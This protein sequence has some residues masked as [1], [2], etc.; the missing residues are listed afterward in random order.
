[1]E[2]KLLGRMGF[3]LIFSMSL[4]VAGCRGVSEDRT[5]TWSPTGNSVGFQHGRD[6]L[7]VWDAEVGRAE[8]IYQP[9][10]DVLA[11]STPLWSPDGNG[12]VFLTATRDREGSDGPTD[13]S[14]EFPEAD[15]DSNPEGRI[16]RK[17]PAQYDCWICERKEDRR[18]GSPRKLFHARCQHIG[19]IAA[20]LAVRWHPSGEKLFYV[21]RTSTNGHQVFAFD[22]E[23]SDSEKALP[24]EAEHVLFDWAPN[25]NPMACVIQGAESPDQD[26]IWI[27]TP[28]EQDW[29]QVPISLHRMREENI[30]WLP[31][32]RDLR[33]VW[34]RD[35]KRFAFVDSNAREKKSSQVAAV[36]HI[37][38]VADRTVRELYRVHGSIRQVQWA[39]DGRKVGY[40]LSPQNQTAQLSVFSSLVYRVLVTHELSQPL[41]VAV[42]QHPVRSFAGWNATGTSLAYTVPTP[43][44]LRPDEEWAFLLSPALAARDRVMVADADGQSSE[45]AVFAG[46]RIAFL[47]W[48]PKSDR[49]SLW[50]TFSPSHT[51]LPFGFPGSGRGLRPGDPAALLDTKTK[52]IQWM[53]IHAREKVQIGHYSL[54]KQDYSEARQWYDQATK[55]FSAEKK[56][57]ATPTADWTADPERFELFHS[58]CLEQ[59]GEHKAAREKL[60]DFFRH[61]Q[62]VRSNQNRD[63]VPLLE[64]Q[65]IERQLYVAQVFLS[66]DAVEAGLEFF[67]QLPEQ[68]PSL[69]PEEALERERFASQLA[70]AQLLLNAKRWEEYANFATDV[71]VP[72]LL[73]EDLKACDKQ[74]IAAV[75][76]K[77]SSAG[78]TLF[79][80]MAEEFVGRLSPKTLTRLLPIWEKSRQQTDSQVARLWIDRFLTLGHRRLEQSEKATAARKRYDINPQ[81]P[82]YDFE[83]TFN[84]PLFDL[85]QQRSVPDLLRALDAR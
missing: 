39:P 81:K 79:P 36:L 37:G 31:E 50:A 4:A 14:S 19:L 68:L 17:L 67:E 10:S 7:F 57:E 44:K 43:T 3:S 45:R 47:N 74:S 42:T 82:K 22:F 1:M 38:E 35:G 20:N 77:I 73:K 8:Q 6:G 30:D 21:N 78:W 5:I 9:P 61:T 60:Q 65:T 58:H 24:F 26:G 23:D 83:A 84:S 25:G 32:L 33:P 49:L 13:V 66:L 75:A 62:P 16:F 34:S 15:W 54:L 27:G 70:R 18:L 52:T 64:V 56:P 55:E 53:P 46:M 41:P 40:L 28:G 48:S 11:T 59:L 63:A 29:W 69:V 72:Q 85:L 76:P 2:R 51:L 12:L 71:I 80:L